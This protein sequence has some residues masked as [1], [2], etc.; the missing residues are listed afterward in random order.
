[1]LLKPLRNKVMVKPSKTSKKSKGGIYLPESSTKVTPF[2]IIISI[3]PDV[4]SKIFQIGSKVMYESQNPIE[5]ELAG[6]KLFV[7]EDHE[8]VALIEDG[9]K[10][11]KED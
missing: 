8:I 2:A 1:M 6:T 4:D 7:I 5:V 9:E 3:G 11:E 10:D